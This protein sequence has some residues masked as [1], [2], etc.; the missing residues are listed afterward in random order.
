[1]YSKYREQLFFFPPACSIKSTLFIT[2]NARGKAL[3]ETPGA[4]RLEIR[5]GDNVVQEGGNKVM[6][7]SLSVEDTGYYK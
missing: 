7:Y 6:I 3:K 5:N 1:M 4:L 2:H